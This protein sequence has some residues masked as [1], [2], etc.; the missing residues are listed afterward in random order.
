MRRKLRRVVAMFAVMITA[1]TIDIAEARWTT[2]TDGQGRHF[3]WFEADVGETGPAASLPCGK[4][5][6]NYPTTY[7]V[8]TTTVVTFPENLNDPTDTFPEDLLPS[9]NTAVS[10]FNASAVGTQ[11][12]GANFVPSTGP[13]FHLRFAGNC[14]ACRPALGSIAVR[15]ARLLPCSLASC[16]LGGVPQHN[17]LAEGVFAKISHAAVFIN[18]HPNADFQPDT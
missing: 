5:T 11:S 17:G 2:I 9:F 16:V 3:R 6:P 12:G 8:C 18:N 1:S 15:P 4:R 10:G 14:P 7:T 13:L